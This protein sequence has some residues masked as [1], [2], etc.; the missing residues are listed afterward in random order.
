MF[1]GCRSRCKYFLCNSPRDIKTASIILK[2]SS[3]F[4]SSSSEASSSISIISDKNFPFFAICIT[5]Y[6]FP[7]CSNTVIAGIATLFSREFSISCEIFFSYSRVEVPDSPSFISFNTYGNSS[8][9]PAAEQFSTAYRH[10]F[11]VLQ[12]VRSIL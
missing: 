5:A 10:E 3:A 9:E 6:S 1:P 8:L 12:I 2:I 11:F 7:S 4:H